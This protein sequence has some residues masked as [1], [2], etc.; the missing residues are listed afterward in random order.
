MTSIPATDSDAPRR[1]YRIDEGARVSGVCTGLAAYTHTNVGII[2]FAFIF[3]FV[4]TGGAFALVY[5][6][7]MF[8]LPSASTSE[9][10]AAAYGMPFNAQELVDQAKQ[11]SEQFK[12]GAQQFKESGWHD[13]AQWR[14]QWRQQRRDF[15]RHIR[16]Q[17]W[18]WRSRAWSWPGAAPYSSTPSAVPPAVPPP[19]YQPGYGAHIDRAKLGYPVTAFVAVRYGSTN[20]VGDEP[21]MREMVKHPGV[22]ECHHVAGDDCYVLKV[23]AASLESLQDVLRDLKGN[24][25]NMTTRT[26]IVLGTVFEKPGLVLTEPD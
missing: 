25:K 7:L 18:M 3:L 16:Q 21:R 15:R 14:A 8:I 17:R 20:Y 6:A 26:T 12:K 2:R 22:L 13:R 4:A 10:H 9:E 11:Y 24:N 5:I 23:V 1:L 19:Q